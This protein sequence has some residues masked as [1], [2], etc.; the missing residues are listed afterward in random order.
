ML[1][2]TMKGE[3]VRA[4]ECLILSRFTHQHRNLLLGTSWRVSFTKDTLFGCTGWSFH[5]RTSL[6]H[7]NRNQYLRVAQ[8]DDLAAQP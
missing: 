8:T 4:A 3:S 7:V 6:P 1:H 5:F 2:K